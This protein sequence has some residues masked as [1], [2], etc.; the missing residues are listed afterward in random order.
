LAGKRSNRCCSWFLFWLN[1]LA[2]MIWFR[3]C[4]RFFYYVWTTW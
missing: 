2:G 4:S 3:C 1:V